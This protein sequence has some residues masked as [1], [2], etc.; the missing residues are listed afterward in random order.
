MGEGPEVRLTTEF[1]RKYMIGKWILSWDFLSGKFVEEPPENFDEMLASLPLQVKSVDCKGKSIYMTLTNGDEYFYVFHN[2]RLTGRWQKTSDYYCTCYIELEDV[3]PLWFRDTKDYAEFV[4]TSNPEILNEYIDRIGPDI[5]TTE[6]TLSAWRKIIQDN[7]RLNITS[8][9]S[10]QNIVGG[11]GDYIKSEALHYAKIA[12]SRN[13]SSLQENEIEKLYEGIRFV[14]RM[15]Y[16]YRGISIRE[17]ADENCR[18][19]EFGS[20][21]KIYAKKHAKKSKTADN[22]FTYWDSRVQK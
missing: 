15:S 18:K 9:L 1:L 17:Y 11:I 3:E 2:I 16:N 7:Q 12:P 4:I 13:A 6:F 14:S 19:G 21:L 22:R 8:I 10:N 5:L 20:H